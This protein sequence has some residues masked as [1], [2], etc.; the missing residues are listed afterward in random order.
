MNYEEE[1]EDIYLDGPTLK[2]LLKA[3]EDLCDELNVP[4][5]PGKIRI[6]TDFGT[7]VVIYYEKD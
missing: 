1:E 5:D 2:E 7:N 6:T 3:C 4:Y